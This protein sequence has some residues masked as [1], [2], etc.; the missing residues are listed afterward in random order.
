MY[1][2]SCNHT[3]NTDTD[4]QE[5][6]RSPA[7]EPPKPVAAPPPPEEEDDIFG[8]VDDDY[9][10]TL[11]AK[12]QAALKAK[13]LGPM[14][15]PVMGPAKPKS[16]ESD[17]EPEQLSRYFEDDKMD[18]DEPAKHQPKLRDAI[19]MAQRL[20]GGSAGTGEKPPNVPVLDFAN[21]TATEQRRSQ[22][23]ALQY[24]DD[25]DFGAGSKKQKRSEDG[26]TSQKKRPKHND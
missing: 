17:E 20:A 10:P 25:E 7:V 9:A 15:G 22:S 5:S 11:S 18:V 4:L 8:D 19:K 1:T 23:K 12:Q 24:N 26:D 16:E 21:P 6:Q 13:T 3:G 2:L 14:L